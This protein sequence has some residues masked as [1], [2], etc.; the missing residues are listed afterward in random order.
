MVGAA[1]GS[2]GHVNTMDD[3]TISGRTVTQVTS[4]GRDDP[5]T[6][7]A[8]RAAVVLRIL[9]GELHLLSNTPWIQNIWF[10]TEPDTPLTWPKVWSANLPQARSSSAIPKPPSRPLNPSQRKAVNTML[11]EVD[12]DRFTII[13]GPP[14]TGKTTVISS[15]VHMSTQLGRKGIWLVAESNVAVKNIAEKLLKDKFLNW[16][17]LVSQ[18]FRRDW[19]VI[20]SHLYP[21]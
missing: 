3:I 13:Q 21:G 11:S 17:L 2:T 14:G 7:E 8:K 5:T 6:A 10:N 18:D 16:K 1:S 12:D 19:C 15:F 9:Q 20:H 4:I